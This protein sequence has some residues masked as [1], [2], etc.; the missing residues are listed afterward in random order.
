VG[1]ALTGRSVL[2]AQKVNRVLTGCQQS[3]IKVLTVLTMLTVQGVYNVNSVL[4]EC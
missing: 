2:T 1:K 4:T 3:V